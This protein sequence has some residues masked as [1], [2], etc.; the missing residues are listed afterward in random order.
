MANSKEFQVRLT[1]DINFTVADG[2]TT[3]DVIDCRGTAI[4]GMIIPSG[5]EGATLTV[6]ASDEKDGTFYDYYTSAGAQ[7][8]ITVGASRYIGFVATDFVGIQFLKFVASSQTGDINIKLVTAP[9]V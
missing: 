3:S 7:V 1:T 2:E 9:L 6:K 5:L 8:T 4:L